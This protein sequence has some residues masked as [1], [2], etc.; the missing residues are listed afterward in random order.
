MTAICKQAGAE[1]V[2]VGIVIE[3]SFQDGRKLLDDM[4]LDV[5]SLARI[6]E[7]SPENIEFID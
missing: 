6:S 3:K 5:Y 1:V 4:G 7:L 2:G